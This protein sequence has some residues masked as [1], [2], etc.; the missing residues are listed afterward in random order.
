MRIFY[1]LCFLFLCLFSGLGLYAQADMSSLAQVDSSQYALVGVS[2]AYLRAQ[3]D[4]ESALET[5]ELM[6]NVVRILD[7]DRYWCQVESEQPYV[8]WCTDRVLV[9]VTALELEEYK[10]APKYLCVA[11]ISSVWEKPCKTSAVLCDMVLCNR[12]RMVL[13]SNGKALVK[14]GYAAVLLPDGR[15][16]WVARNDVIP[17]ESWRAKTQAQTSLRRELVSFARSFL[18]IPYLWGGMS[19]K[20]FDCSGLVRVVYLYHG[21]SLPRNA[22]QM[23]LLGRQVDAEQLQEGD[24]MFFGVGEK[25]THIA[26]Y[27]GNGRFIHSSHQVRINSMSSDD[28]DVYE[29]MHKLLF[30][31]NILD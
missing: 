30:C 21:I 10:K 1:K 15:Q 27:V 23:A 12:L 11:S 26:L 25:V 16:G 17:E 4:Y 13:R 3:A 2:T 20:G 31:R 14:G 24:L 5:Q 8:A 7:K 22:S 19:P 6:G 18:G 29:N 9:P 28:A